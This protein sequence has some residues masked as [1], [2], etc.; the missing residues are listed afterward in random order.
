MP[1]GSVPCERSF[2]ALRCL[3]QWNRTTMAEDRLS[4]LALLYIH[5]N[6]NV[7]GQNTRQI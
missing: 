3:K 7:D 5:R 2:S 4:G 1:I 6:V